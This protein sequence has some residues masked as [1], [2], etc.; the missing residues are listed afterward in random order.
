VWIDGALFYWGGDSGYGG[1]VHDDG[2]IYDPVSAQWIA[3][4]H[5]PIPGRTSAAAVWTGREVIQG[6]GGYEGGQR[7]G[8][9]DGAAFDPFACKWRQIA[10]A[11][12]S[13]R[14]LLAAVW[15]G[16]VAL[17]WG[18]TARPNGAEDGAAYDPGTDSW[19]RI[20][21]APIS[22]N[23]GAGVWT[24]EEMIVFGSQLDNNNA[25]KTDYAIGAAYNPVADQ[26]RN[27]PPVTMSPQASA[28]AWTGEEMIAWDYELSAFA[29]DPE[30]NEWRDIPDVPLEFGECYP[31]TDATREHLLAYFCGAAAVLAIEEGT[32][33]EIE[34][35]LLFGR[36]VAA[37]NVF[38]LAGAAHESIRNRLMLFKPTS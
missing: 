15:T 33:S 13:A 16:D 22:I 8:L 14:D 38:L 5:A 36:P 1:T 37:G 9:A 12:L 29:Y 3:I 20:A 28:I 11:P 2:A 19:R 21:D 32:W 6:G 26:W 24:G 34:T 31:V 23:A 17:F 4:P 18:S 25:S 30:T 27:L 7:A 10:T 35:P